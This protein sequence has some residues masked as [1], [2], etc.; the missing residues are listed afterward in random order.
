MT[1][2]ERIAK[3][4]NHHQEQQHQLEAVLQCVPEDE[5]A[6]DWQQIE[7]NDQLAGLD[8]GQ[9]HRWTSRQQEMWLQLQ[10]QDFARESGNQVN[11]LEQEA[12]LWAA[13]TAPTQQPAAA[14]NAVYTAAPAAVALSNSAAVFVPAAQQVYVQV[15]ALGVPVIP[16]FEALGGDATFDQ[17]GVG[18]EGGVGGGDE[19]VDGSVEDLEDLMALLC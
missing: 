17:W 6:G 14:Y 8:V 11:V 18:V 12:A 1:E 4:F 5:D 15:A 2:V 10:E 3:Q 9:W 19:D 13:G 7:G 16:D